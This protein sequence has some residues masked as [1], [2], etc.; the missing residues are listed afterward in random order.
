[1]AERY[2]HIGHDL[3][4]QFTATRDRL[5]PYRIGRQ[6]QLQ[7]WQADWDADARDVHHRHVSHLYGVYPGQQIGAA[8]TPALAAA[9]RRSL[10]IR[11]DEATGW[12]TAWRIALW[13]RLRDG[14][15]AHHILRFLIGPKRTY[16]NMFDAHP[17]FQIDGNFGGA[18]AIAEMLMSSAYGEITLLPALP[19]AWPRGRVKG[20]RARGGCEVDL[21]WAAGRLVEALV[22]PHVAGTITL[23][24]GGTTRTLAVTPQIKVRLVGPDLVRA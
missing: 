15:R 6:G 17:P 23:V 1:M 9:A 20:L 4:R 7:E 10:D 5:A 14:N 13:A 21:S 2:R 11:G 16:P 19:D 3:A 22:T 12:A 8:T 18:A 24:S